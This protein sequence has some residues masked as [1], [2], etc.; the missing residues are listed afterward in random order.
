MSI[1]Q[2]SPN[3]DD[4]AQILNAKYIELSEV[5]FLQLKLIKALDLKAIKEKSCSTALEAQPAIQNQSTQCWSRPL[6]IQRSLK[7]AC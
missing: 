7:T 4:C 6:I 3:L 2:A 5:P 1:L